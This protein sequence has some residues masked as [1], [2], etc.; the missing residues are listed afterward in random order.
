MS[1]FHNYSLIF[2]GFFPRKPFLPRTLKGFAEERRKV[3]VR[4][5]GGNDPASTTGRGETGEVEN[6]ALFGE[7][8]ERHENDG[9]TGGLTLAVLGYSA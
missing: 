7:G 4:K 2:R 1:V 8:S 6:C 3:R 9:R 5:V